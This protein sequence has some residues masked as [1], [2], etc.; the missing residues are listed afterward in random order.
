MRSAAARGKLGAGGTARNLD[1]RC[2]DSHPL[3][4]DKRRNAGRRPRV[5]DRLDRQVDYA[6]NATLTQYNPLGHVS[7]VT[8]ADGYTI[9]F[10]RDPI[11]RITGAY[12]QEGHRVSLS[13]DAEGKPRSST[14]P[15]NLST[16]YEYYHAA[17]DGRLKKT[18]LPT[19]AGQT[20]G[21]AVEVASYDGAGRPTQINTVA[22]D[23]SVRDS[24]RFYDA[25]GRLTR[26]VGPQVSSTDANRPVS[27]LVYTALSDVK[28]IWA[29][30]TT[31]TASKT[32]TLDSVTVK[33]QVASSYDDFGRKLSQTDQ[34]GQTWR[35]T[36]N[37]HNQPVSSQTPTQI[38]AGQST[39]YAWGS[40]ANTGET[41][42]LLKSRT[43][44]GAQTASTCLLYTSPSPRD[45]R[46][47]R[48]PSSA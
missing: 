45:K 1:S 24:Y 39:S 17:Q 33:K 9:G 12:N 32:C 43:V 20:Q 23:G 11:G 34:N 40:K 42:G 48:M 47:S 15:N 18:M 14:D 41:Q 25:L 31:D 8:E 28:E 16:Q 30:A 22:A 13:L 26:A 27:C 36:W 46:Q 19:V 2:A 21:R 3:R 38:A 7:A 6:G 37:R 44:P 10:E 35:W 29:G 4:G 5:G